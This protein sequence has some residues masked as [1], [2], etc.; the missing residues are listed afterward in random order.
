MSINY[1]LDSSVLILSLNKDQAIHSKLA[2]MNALYTSTIALGE[3]YYGA[4]RSRQVARNIAEINELAKD[5]TI[6]NIDA[7]TA[8]YYAHF[9]HDQEKR[10]LKL[11]ENDLWI[12]A[13]AMQFGLT[14][15]A[16]DH[17]FTW[18]PGLALEQW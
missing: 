9:K 14:L 2:E 12:A 7:K 1:L 6:L 15:V 10:G 18:I 8:R 11:P 16:R 3:L 17:H 4:E 13:T 5:L